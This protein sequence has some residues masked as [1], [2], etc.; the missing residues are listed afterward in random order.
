MNSLSSTSCLS[1]AVSV[2][3]W[4]QPAIQEGQSATL[5]CQVWTSRLTQLNYT[6]Y[7]DG[8]QWPGT[9]SISLPNVTV[10]DAA[11]Y[12]CGVVTPGQAPRLSRP[13]ALDVLC[14]SAGAQQ[15]LGEI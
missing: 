10:V 14:K 12:R 11:S 9:G 6:W 3:I 1:S 2:Q 8:R 5:T 13:V 4:P 7:Q 15:E